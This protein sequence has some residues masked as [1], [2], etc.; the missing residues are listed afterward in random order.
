MEYVPISVYRAHLA[1]LLASVQ[2]LTES[3]SALGL[4][5][6]ERGTLSPEL[7]AKFLMEVSQSEDA[8][9]VYHQIKRLLDEN[10]ALEAVFESEKWP[11]Q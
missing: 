10:L 11:I 1:G 4:A 6:R 9:R 3:T 7:Y 5:L 2:K 8:K